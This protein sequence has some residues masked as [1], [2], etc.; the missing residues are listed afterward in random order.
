MPFRDLEFNCSAPTSRSGS[1][2]VLAPPFFSLKYAGKTLV[3]RT[4]AVRAVPVH[5]AGNVAV[6]HAARGGCP[7]AIS[8]AS[9]LPAR[10]RA[11]PAYPALLES[12]KGFCAFAAQDRRG[13]TYVVAAGSPV[14]ALSLDP[15]VAAALPDGIRGFLDAEMARFRVTMAEALVGEAPSVGAQAALSLLREPG[16]RCIAGRGETGDACI[17][18]LADG[19]GRYAVVGVTRQ[20]ATLTILFPFLAPGRE[21][22]AEWID[23]SL[24]YYVKGELEIRPA[25]VTC[26][27]K[28]VV[29][30]SICGGFAVIC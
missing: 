14:A 11:A 20:S 26:R 16:W 6:I 1:L 2:G 3:G 24:D 13:E 9:S 17:W 27:T 15:A 18:T 4:K 10:F 30:T 5:I 22:A 29:K 12:R 21:C 28:A 23:D 19:K 8:W 7:A 25:S